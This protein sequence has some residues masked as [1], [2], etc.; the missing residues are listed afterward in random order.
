MHVSSVDIKFTF[1][2]AVYPWGSEGELWARTPLQCPSQ[3][4]SRTTNAR[5]E[6]NVCQYVYSMCRENLFEQKILSVNVFIERHK[7]K[8]NK[9]LSPFKNLVNEKNSMSLTLGVYVKMLN[10]MSA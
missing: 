4:P 10:D 1:K 7:E 6:L 3:L 8:Q 2:A 9:V 5:F